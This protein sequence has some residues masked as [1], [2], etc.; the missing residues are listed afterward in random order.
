MNHHDGRGAKIPANASS[1]DGP[2]W[3]AIEPFVSI[4]EAGRTANVQSGHRRIISSNLVADRHR[5]I[6]KRFG[7]A[8]GVVAF[9]IAIS[10]RPIV[11]GQPGRGLAKTRRFENTNKNLSQPR[12]AR[13]DPSMGLVIKPITIRTIR[14]GKDINRARRIG[15]P[16]SDPGRVLEL[17]PARLSAGWADRQIPGLFAQIPALVIEQ[18]RNDGMLP[19]SREIERERRM[20]GARGIAG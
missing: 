14:V 9:V 10:R 4:D 19:I 1:R 16:I 18:G 7:L 11:R 20:P 13:V 6:R 5:N 2:W 15:R 8:S 3:I 17:S 12:S